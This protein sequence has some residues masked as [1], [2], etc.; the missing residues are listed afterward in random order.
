MGDFLLQTVQAFLLR[1]P[2]LTAFL[3]RF[4]VPVEQ[5]IKT[6]AF[7]CHMCAQCVLHSTGMICP[8]TCPKSL[9]N[10]PC[11]GVRLNGRC[12]VKP[13]MECVWLKAYRRSQVLF[14]PEEFHDLRAPVDWSL[15]G[16][17]SWVNYLTGR[18][19][20]ISGCE[21]EPASAL[22]VIDEHG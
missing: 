22:E 11:G 19:R 12:E 15:K 8:M 9:R 1:H 17:S 16:G 21:P 5:V 18:D 4:L 7:G 3:A 20:I 14:W 6:P 2:Q 13:E 10:G